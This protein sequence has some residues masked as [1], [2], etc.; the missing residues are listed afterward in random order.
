MLAVCP[1]HVQQSR[2]ANEAGIG[3]LLVL[4]PLAALLK[5]GLPVSDDR[6]APPNMAW[7]GLAGIL[8]G[9]CCYGYFAVRLFLPLFLIATVV[10]NW[11]SCRAVART[12]T[13]ASAIAALALGVAATFGPLFLQ[14]AVHADEMNLRG[15]QTWVW[16]AGDPP[17]VRAA[18]VI[19]RYPAHFG[20]DFLFSRGDHY[21]IQA[22]PEGG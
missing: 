16:S 14:H 8:C 10:V 22:P 6:D 18:K 11:R 19:A 17:I 20:P 1:W 5:A 13:G 7:A 2:W 15:Q 3:T 9:V 4:L 12:R 21:V